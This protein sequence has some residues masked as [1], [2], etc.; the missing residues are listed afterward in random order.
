M[1]SQDSPVEATCRAGE[2]RSRPR[3]GAARA[4]GAQSAALALR[5]RAGRRGD[6]RAGARRLP[7]LEPGDEGS[8][9][10]DRDLRE[11]GRRLDGW[12][13]ALLPVRRR[14]DRREPAPGGDGSWSRHTPG[15]QIR[16]ER[17]QKISKSRAS[18]AL[19]SSRRS[20]TRSSRATTRRRR[21]DFASERERSGRDHPLREVGLAKARLTSTSSVLGLFCVS[22]AT[23]AEVMAP[24]RQSQ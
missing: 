14:S 10:P 6:R 19:F 18:T 1:Q 11:A 22:E 24:I 13:Q 12:P 2:N 9:A 5:A 20:P 7:G 4:L 3:R 23:R 16:R 8:P 17:G 15:A 21:R